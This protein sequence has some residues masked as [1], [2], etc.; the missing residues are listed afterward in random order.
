MLHRTLA[1]LEAGLEV[2]E[3]SPADVGRVEMIVRRPRTNEREELNEGELDP[4]CGL[5]GDVWGGSSAQAPR[6]VD[7]Q[8][9]LMNSRVIELIAGGR[10]RWA[11]AGDQLFVD[12]DLS[13]DNLPVGT[14]LAL[15]TAVI[16]VTSEPHTGCRK[17]VAR[18]GA[19]AHKFVNSAL[20]R[21][22]N[23]RGIYARV[24]QAGTVRQ[25]AEVSKLV[26]DS[27]DA[28]DAASDH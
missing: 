13:D 24:V 1:E 22:L 9:T 23:L 4:K 3:S 25:G 27:V 6:A 16:E 8:L 19:D 7:T 12:L 2:V 11:L 5:V 15:G 28:C 14:R 26:S 10:E 21:E 20:G 17:F 18:F